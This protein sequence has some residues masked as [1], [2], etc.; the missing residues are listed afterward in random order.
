MCSGQESVMKP[1]LQMSSHL[2]SGLWA[3][4]W[5]AWKMNSNTANTTE[6]QVVKGRESITHITT[7]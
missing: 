4:H 3:E 2:G 7:M 6:A 5:R 1:D